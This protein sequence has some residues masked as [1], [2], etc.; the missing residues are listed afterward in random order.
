MKKLPKNRDIL[1]R[2]LHVHDIYEGGY[3]AYKEKQAA[4]QVTQ[5][6][7]EVWQFHFGNRLVY[8][9]DSK[10]AE[11]T[12]ESLKI[13]IR[14]DHVETKIVKLFKLWTELERVNRREDRNK[15]DSFL[16]KVKNMTDSLD[17]PMNI[18]KVYLTEEILRYNSGINDWKEDSDHLNN[19]LRK[20]QL[21]SVAGYD[22]KQ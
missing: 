12:N 2:F 16:Q 1:A 14:K 22:K 13:V 7:C 3:S 15:K 5:E 20:D 11:T 9:K 18:S 19:Q 6:I 17:E 8:G 4:M 21:G 10:E